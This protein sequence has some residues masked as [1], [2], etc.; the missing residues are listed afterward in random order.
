MHWVFDRSLGFWCV[1]E[2]PCGHDGIFRS[3]DGDVT[4][5]KKAAGAGL[6]FVTVRG[7]LVVTAWRDRV[8]SHSFTAVELGGNRI[9][10]VR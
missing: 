5:A 10:I 3:A 6:A 4:R 7:W 8:L 2:G 9:A 1:L